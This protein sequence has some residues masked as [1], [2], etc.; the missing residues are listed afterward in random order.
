MPISEKL[1]LETSPIGTHEI[2][3][4]FKNQEKL[5]A[6]FK[7]HLY[8]SLSQPHFHYF[9]ISTLNYFKFDENYF[10]VVTPTRHFKRLLYIASGQE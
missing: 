3:G 1:K 8:Y 7:S 9:Q 4:W 10:S 5:L 2:L 6:E